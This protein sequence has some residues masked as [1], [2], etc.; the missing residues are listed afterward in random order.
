MKTQD[1]RD[2]IEIALLDS[3]DLDSTYA[4]QANYI[5]SVLSVAGVIHKPVT[6]S[7]YFNIYDSEG[8]STIFRY[9]TR[10]E[11]D[12]QKSHNRI[13]VLRLDITDGVITSHIE[14]G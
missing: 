8:A 9:D 11:A 6:I 7:R 10:E 4:T 2:L 5:L 3:T 1:I 13:A 12:R 14:P